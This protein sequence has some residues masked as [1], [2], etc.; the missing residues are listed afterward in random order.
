MTKNPHV[1]VLAKVKN[2][3][4]KLIIFLLVWAFIYWISNTNF[5]V[6]SFLLACLFVYTVNKD[7]LIFLAKEFDKNHNALADNVK[8]L[9]GRLETLEDENNDLKQE[10]TDLTERI[11]DLEAPKR[12][13]FDPLYDFI[14]EI[15]KKNK[16][17]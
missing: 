7:A 5:G 8:E 15:E 6:I 13:G 14:D 17:P 9:Y 10:I 3:L 11:S 4:L 16:A 2:K 1:G 12:T